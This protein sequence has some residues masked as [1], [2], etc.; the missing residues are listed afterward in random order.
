MSLR[1]PRNVYLEMVQRRTI[2]TTRTP[3]C[4][5]VAKNDTVHILHGTGDLSD[6]G[7]TPDAAQHDEIGRSPLEHMKSPRWLDISRRRIVTT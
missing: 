2:G 5:A 4:L 6:E 1:A 3:A 7:V